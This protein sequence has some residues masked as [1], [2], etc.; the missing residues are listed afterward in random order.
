MRVYGTGNTAAPNVGTAARRAGSGRF[1][2]PDTEATR[3]PA[4]ATG[5]RSITG[6]DALM[7]LQAFDD[8]LERRR[9]A[10][11]QGRAAL[12]ALEDLK[13]GLLAGSLDPAA[14]SRLV[15]VAETLGDDAGE[16]KLNAVMAEI[17]LRA[18]VELAKFS[19]K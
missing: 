15:L 10:V 19:R 11:K 9:R 8:P 5:P 4:A 13:V 2:L 12:D 14:L 7:A 18:A 3:A 1:S 16:E 17:A 6:L